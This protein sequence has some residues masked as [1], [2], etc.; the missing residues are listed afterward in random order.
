[1][2]AS[3]QTGHAASLDFLNQLDDFFI[4]LGNS[5]SAMQ[6]LSNVHP[7]SALRSA[8]SDCQKKL[9]E[10]NTDV[11][12]SSAIYEQ[13]NTITLETDDKIALRYKKAVR[14]LYSL[15]R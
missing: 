13:L 9:S 12:L 11:S 7:N 1:M 4:E 6:L 5:Y 14:I 8:A 15:W 10:L 3:S 2:P